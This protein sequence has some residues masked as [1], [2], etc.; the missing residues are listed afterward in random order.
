MTWVIEQTIK[1]Y[2]EDFII[3]TMLVNV[4]E[5]QVRFL[6]LWETAVPGYDSVWY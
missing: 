4:S 2:K 6:F 3:S 5:G 1:T